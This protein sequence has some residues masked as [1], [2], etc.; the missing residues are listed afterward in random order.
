VKSHRDGAQRA[1][2]LLVTESQAVWKVEGIYCFNRNSIHP[3]S[4]FGD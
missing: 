3:I 4:Q 2:F 1:A